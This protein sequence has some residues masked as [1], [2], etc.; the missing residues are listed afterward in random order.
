M[1]GCGEHSRRDRTAVVLV[2]GNGYAFFTAIEPPDHVCDL[3]IA[4]C[5][6]PCVD[7]GHAFG[8][9]LHVALRQTSRGDQE[10]A[11]AVLFVFRHFEQS[12]DRLFLCAVYERASV[13]DDDIRLRGV[14]RKAEP[15][16]REPTEH[17]F[18]VDPV[19]VA[20]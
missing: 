20:A 9:L 7:L 10:F 15:L 13:D 16:A 12:R 5:A 3:V 18:G 8:K 1:L 2:V 19:L 14:L 11:L 4:R 6:Q 17:L